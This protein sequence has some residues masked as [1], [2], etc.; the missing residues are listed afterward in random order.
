LLSHW[1]ISIEF[2]AEASKLCF[3][4]S[5]SLIFSVNAVVHTVNIIRQFIVI[6]DERQSIKRRRWQESSSCEGMF[7][8][9]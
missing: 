7:K 1:L 6:Q 5:V 3:P 4:I 8:D 2:P 9:M